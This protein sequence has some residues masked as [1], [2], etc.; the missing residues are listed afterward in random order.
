MTNFEI[1]K[2]YAHKRMLDTVMWVTSIISLDHRSRTD[3]VLL[4]I[5]WYTKEGRSLNAHEI[6][7]INRSEFSNWYK[8]K[9]SL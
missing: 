3:C 6:V 7:Q 5:S 8:F 1:N 4:S 2:L 9:E